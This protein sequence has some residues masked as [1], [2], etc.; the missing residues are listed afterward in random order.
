MRYFNVK[1]TQNGEACPHSRPYKKL[2][3]IIH[4]LYLIKY[5]EDYL[6]YYAL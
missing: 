1:W 6:K 2:L 5:K 3:R 4:V